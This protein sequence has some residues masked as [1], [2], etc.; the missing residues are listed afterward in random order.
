MVVRRDAAI[1]GGGAPFV[2]SLLALWFAC[3]FGGSSRWPLLSLEEASSP[4]NRRNCSPSWSPAFSGT[5]FARRS[6]EKQTATWTHFFLLLSARLQRLWFFSL[7]LLI[8]EPVT[9]CV[10][11]DN[12]WLC[13]CFCWSV[14]RNGIGPLGRTKVLWVWLR[15]KNPADI[16]AGSWCLCWENTHKHTSVVQS[17][18][19]AAWRSRR[20]AP[21][22]VSTQ[23]VFVICR[24]PA[25][26]Q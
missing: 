5:I 18:S 11:V 15:K 26:D 4:E 23:P 6:V 19:R 21:S 14:C 3:C 16:E 9:W 25:Q 7:H 8:C 2:E 22:S 13:S 12:I 24:F 17:L 1:G 10:D 20:S